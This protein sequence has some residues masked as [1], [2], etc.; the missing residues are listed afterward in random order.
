MQI[1]EAVRAAHT[2]AGITRAL[3][4]GMLAGMIAGLIWL[5]IAA[6]TNRHLSAVSMLI[7]VGVAHGV[8]LGGGRGI[9][10]QAMSVGLTLGALLV[11]E[12]FVIRL[13]AVR[14]LVELGVTDALPILLPFVVMKDLVSAGLTSDPPTALF[15]GIAL[16]YAI[17]VPRRTKHAQDQIGFGR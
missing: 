9:R 1:T 16:W 5:G 11:T 6:L 15:W 8:L 12:A 4:L 17:S 2:R 13:L 10:Y 14:E 3:A 7:G